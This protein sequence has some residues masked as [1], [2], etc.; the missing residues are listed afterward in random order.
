MTDYAD[1]LRRPMAASVHDWPARVRLRWLCVVALLQP[2]C[3][4]LHD[5]VLLRDAEDRMRQLLP[6]ARAAAMMEELRRH[7][8]DVRRRNGLSPG[9]SPALELQRLGW[10]EP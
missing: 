2:L 9:M 6:D 8:K 3:R 1:I 10:V 4:V 7:R 5:L